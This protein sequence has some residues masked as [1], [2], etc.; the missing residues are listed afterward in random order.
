MNESY[1]ESFACFGAMEFLVAST[2]HEH[3]EAE[4]TIAGKHVKAVSYLT[5]L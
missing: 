3:K 5:K 4:L 1:K 2:G